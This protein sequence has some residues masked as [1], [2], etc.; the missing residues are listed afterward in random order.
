[1]K[2]CVTGYYSLNPSREPEPPL[3]YDLRAH[4]RKTADSLGASL[5]F[6]EPGPFNIHGE[7][8]ERV[9]ADIRYDIVR[10]GNPDHLYIISE[11][12][13]VPYPAGLKVF[14]D[15]AREGARAGYFAPYVNRDASQ[16]PVDHWPLTGAWFL[17]LNLKN[18]TSWPPTY[19]LAAGGPYHDAANMALQNALASGFLTEE[20]VVRLA[21]RDLWGTGGPMSL[22][23]PGLG[24]H[25]F[26]SAH[27]EDPPD[28]ELLLGSGYTSGEHVGRVKRFLLRPEV[29]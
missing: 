18:V 4:W 20:N 12:D 9:W 28:A 19:W 16:V 8:L 17:A 21:W 14:A 6:Y 5:V 2:I 13:F 15:M 10:N 29:Q 25:L 3:V 22:E 24:T 1:M 23:L 7:V 26:F 27:F 11:I